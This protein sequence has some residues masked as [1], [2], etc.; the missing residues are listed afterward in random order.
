ML[1]DINKVYA[2]DINI[3]E[4]I[5]F[6]PEFYSKSIIKELDTIKVSGKITMNSLNEINI[7]LLI[8]GNMY[9]NDAVTL[10]LVKIPL[11]ITLD[12]VIDNNDEYFCIDNN[13]MDLKEFV[14]KNIVLEIPIRAVSDNYEETQMEGK[15][16]SLNKE[17]AEESVFSK[18]NELFEKEEK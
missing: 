12:E 4:D 1:I 10:E 9:L 16:W 15:G 14:W 13:K 3:N 17:V 6:E 11:D 18:L 7:N 5:F 2:T 8:K